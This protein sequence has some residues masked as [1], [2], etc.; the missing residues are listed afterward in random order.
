MKKLI[1]DLESIKKVWY[2][3]MTKLSSEILKTKDIENAKEKIIQCG[4]DRKIYNIVSNILEMTK[5]RFNI[6]NESIINK[7]IYLEKEIKS[8]IKDKLQYL[9]KNQNAH[10][11]CE[12]MYI[13]YLSGLKQGYEEVAKTFMSGDNDESNNQN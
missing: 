9:D 4:L 11:D 2:D 12:N 7:R 1:E 13:R 5:I 8:H 3:E 6:I 10:A